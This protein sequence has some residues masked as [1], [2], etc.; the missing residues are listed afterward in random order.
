[1]YHWLNNSLSMTGI[2]S[3]LTAD[4]FNTDMVNNEHN[5]D[6]INNQASTYKYITIHDQLNAHHP[7]MREQTLP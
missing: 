3:H 1:M 4:Q 2:I 5:S 7:I 6:K